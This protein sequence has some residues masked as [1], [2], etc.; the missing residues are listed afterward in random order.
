MSEEQNLLFEAAAP[1][2][3]R[4]KRQAKP[5]KVAAT[6]EGDAGQSESAEPPAKPAK[7]PR[8]RKVA[9]PASAGTSAAESAPEKRTATVTD[10]VRA[11]T[12][13]SSAPRKNARSNEASTPRISES[14]T[15]TEIR[16]QTVAAPVESVRSEAEPRN[17]ARQ[18]MGRRVGEASAGGEAVQKNDAV[19]T[20][21]PPQRNNA[22]PGWENRQRRDH[23]TQ[24]PAQSGE[25][26]TTMVEHRPRPQ[27]ESGGDREAADGSGA[28]SSM[29]KSRR[30]RRKR[31]NRAAV[32]A[33]NVA[34][35]GQ[36]NHAA[37]IDA[38][39]DQASGDNV[40][41][42][43]VRQNFAPGNG[44]SATGQG[45]GVVVGQG[46]QSGGGAAVIGQGFQSG[47]G[48]GQAYSQNGQNNGQNARRNKKKKFRRAGEGDSG[49]AQNNGFQ[50]NGPRPPRPEP[51]NSL[52]GSNSGQRR[53][54]KQGGGGSNGGG[55]SR[56]PRTFVGPMDHS[57][58]EANGNFADVP[59]STIQITQRH[60]NGGHRHFNEDRLPPELMHNNRPV[61][62]PEDAPTHIYFFIEDLFFTAKIQE[63]AKQQGVKVA[64][65][66]PEKDVVAHLSELHD[67]EHPSLIVFDLNNVNAKPL[68]LIP[69][70]KAKLKKGT[71]ILGFLSHLQGD[72]KQKAVEAGCHTV[73]PRSA[74]SQN[75]PNLLRRYGVEDEH[76]PNFNQ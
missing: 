53:N 29:S 27:A 62:I 65:M 44:G 15:V 2:P 26:T 6:G 17:D 8:T 71:S 61:A 69:K 40:P 76:E 7:A 35:A 14:N 39:A 33:A 38:A 25:G 70:L 67:H 24:T 42:Q 11:A 41:P 59:A 56:G 48:G 36:E 20:N 51:G 57:Y 46:F 63:A 16:P 1:T 28:E 68:T 60:R 55:Q 64:F 74:F 30:R 31:K 75:L 4:A 5:K 32:N 9:T 34:A 22:R 13:E 10:S 23:A 3:P 73:M 19:L 72:L 47:S 66:K 50:Q 58:R 37:R 21:D 12:E 43:E 49:G 45:A 18:D 54:R 52:Q